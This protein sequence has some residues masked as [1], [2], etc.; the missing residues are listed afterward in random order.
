MKS[1]STWLLGGALAASLTWNVTGSR[2]AG[3][4][5]P[6]STAPAACAVGAGCAPVS[7]GMD[8]PDEKRAALEALCARSCGE[9]DALE[10]EADALQQ[11]LLASL[12]ADE[13]DAEATAR[14]VAEV[15]ELRRRSLATCVD[16]ILGVRAVLTGAEVRALLAACEHA[17]A[18][19][20]CR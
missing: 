20:T 5:P 15:S 17:S 4:A 18:T 12:S 2:A 9:S 6:G 3:D 13:V 14:L 11:R 19:E 7:S 1:L 8:L 10:R 16:G